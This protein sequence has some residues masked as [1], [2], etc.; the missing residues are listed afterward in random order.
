MKIFDIWKISFN[1]ISLTNELKN[2]ISEE[3]HCIAKKFL[4]LTDYKKYIITHAYLRILLSK[5]YKKIK[6]KDWK[7]IKNKYGK[8]QISREHNTSLYFNLSHTSSCMYTMFCTYEKIGIDVEDKRTINIEENMIDLIFSENE[9]KYFK[10][11][12][13][14]L[15]LFYKYWTLKE[16]YL[17]AIGKGLYIDPRTINFNSK[18]NMQD[19]NLY[20]KIDEKNHCFL[21]NFNDDYFLSYT[22]LD[23]K[24][25]TLNPSFYEV[26]SFNKILTYKE[27]T[28]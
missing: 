24:D 16:S 1:E 18:I 12:N 8:P 28:I 15:S 20:F 17:K 5:Y 22:V 27:I 21:H 10:S 7:F 14:D 2:I 6:P 11:K 9:K 23:C 3:E 25:K 13:N 26:T 19:K 4:K